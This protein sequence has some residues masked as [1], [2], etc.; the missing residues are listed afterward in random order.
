M[1]YHSH[2]DSSVKASF[3]DA[4]L[5]SLAPGGGLWMPDALPKYSPNETARLGAMSFAD[6]AAELAA[7]FVDEKFTAADLKNI[8]R[9][10]Y[11]FPVPM[12]TLA[13][14]TLDPALAPDAE[15]FVLELFHGPTLA[16]KDFAA[17]FMG[18]AASHIMGKTKQRRTILV[19][20]SGDTGGAIGDAFLDQEGIKVFILFPKG[21]VS[22]VQEQQLTTMGNTRSN[23]KAI[24]VDG[25]FDDCQQ[26]VKQAFGN[27]ALCEEHDLMSANSINVG[28]VIPQSFYYFWTSL[29]AKAAYPSRPLVYA[30]PSGNLGNLTGGL[31][32]KQMGAPINRFVIGNNANDPFVDYL[33]TGEYTPRP[34]V[35][36][37]SNAM[38]IG[39]PNNFPRILALHGEDYTE[40][41]KVCWG[42]SFSDEETE[43]HIRRVHTE[44]GYVMCPHTAVGHLAM[45]KFAEDVSDPF[46]RITVGT[47]HPAKFADSVERIL[48]TDIP[49]PEPLAKAMRKKKRMHVM[50][51]TLDALSEYLAKHA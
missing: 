13:G 5:A 9:D 2:Q 8:C 51:P 29:Q 25:S 31:I 42:A 7:N 43:R 21:G 40:V 10:A 32:A 33:S 30:I 14:E 24:A 47:A 11:N 18:R 19:A 26:L 15:D 48:H 17:R 39:R 37:L 44:T 50:S 22:K 49:L 45:E 36:T 1:N 12:V 28:R 41:T 46:T 6:C 3:S 16:F 35:P 4:L 27:N 23:V 38:D 34:S 20:T